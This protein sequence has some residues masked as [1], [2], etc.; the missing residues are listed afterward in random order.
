MAGRVRHG[1]LRDTVQMVRGGGIELEG[2]RERF[3][4]LYLQSVRARG[5]GSQ[6]GERCGQAAALEKMTRLWDPP[7]LC[8]A[9]RVDWVVQT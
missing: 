1:F 2:H 4:E 8:E 5:T 9:H 6:L 3:A 7:D